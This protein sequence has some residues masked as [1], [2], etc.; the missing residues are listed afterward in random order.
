MPTIPTRWLGS[1]GRSAHLLSTENTTDLITLADEAGQVLYTSLSHQP[2]LGYDPATLPPAASVV[3]AVHPDDRTAVAYA[4]RSALDDG[5]ADVTSR[6]RLAGVMP[7]PGSKPTCARSRSRPV[8][9]SC[10]SAAT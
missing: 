4:W 3:T 6:F 7:T 8:A 5:Q 9:R 10:S 2:V 1:S